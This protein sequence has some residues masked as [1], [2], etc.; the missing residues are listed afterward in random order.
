[1]G[2]GKAALDELEQGRVKDKP[3]KLAQAGQDSYPRSVVADENV[4]VLHLSEKRITRMTKDGNAVREEAGGFLL[5]EWPSAE[6]VWI[7]PS[8]CS[9]VRF[10][11]S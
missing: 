2:A 9:L 6:A 10:P 8:F 1:M 11:S 3:G 7:C 5:G 4:G